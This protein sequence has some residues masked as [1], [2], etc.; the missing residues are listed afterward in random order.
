V[1]DECKTFFFDTAA[2][3]VLTWTER[4]WD[5]TAGGAAVQL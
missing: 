4:R 5:S 1:I 2:A 3:L